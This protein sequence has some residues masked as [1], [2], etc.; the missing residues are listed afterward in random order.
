MVARTLGKES[1]HNYRVR[2]AEVCARIID[3]TRGDF[4][5]F[6]SALASVEKCQD[7][8][9]TLNLDPTTRESLD[10]MLT[11][12]KK[13]CEVTGHLLDNLSNRFDRNLNL[14]CICRFH[15]C[16]SGC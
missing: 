12:Q 3:Q 5:A 15:P 9:C 7:L 2:R 14:V 13:Q 11:E 8:W 16:P 10:T 6:Q 1:D 4:K